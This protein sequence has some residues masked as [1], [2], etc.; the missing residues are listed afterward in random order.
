MGQS[1]TLVL[2]KRNR[3][4]PTSLVFRKNCEDLRAPHT[5]SRLRRRPLAMHVARRATRARAEQRKKARVSRG[6]R[7]HVGRSGA[8]ADVAGWREWNSNG[9]RLASTAHALPVSVST[10]SGGRAQSATRSSALSRNRSQVCTTDDENSSYRVR[11]LSS[12]PRFESSS[13]LH[14]RNA[15]NSCRTLPR[16]TERALGGNCAW[17]SCG[18][19]ARESARPQVPRRVPCTRIVQTK[20]GFAVDRPRRA[21]VCSPHG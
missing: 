2:G 18:A 21:R 9:G 3:S 12:M 15:V 17:R 1:S 10:T 6:R 16:Q 5:H 19:S 20:Q 7:A 4:I 14:A 13:A 11:R 8:K